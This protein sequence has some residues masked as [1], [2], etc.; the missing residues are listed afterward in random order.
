MKIF[1][2]AVAVCSLLVRVS[3]DNYGVSAK[4]IECGAFCDIEPQ[5]VYTLDKCLRQSFGDKNVTGSTEDG[6]HRK[7]A[8]MPELPLYME[9]GSEITFIDDMLFYLKAKSSHWG[10]RIPRAIVFAENS[11]DVV[12]AI[13]C[14]RKSG[15]KVT[16]RGRGHS[17]D[18]WGSADGAVVIDMQYTCDVTKMIKS[19]DRSQRGPHLIPG[20]NYIA[21]IKAQAGCSNINWLAAVYKGF[22]KEE[23]AI[24]SVRIFYYRLFLSLSNHNLT[25]FLLIYILNV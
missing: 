16:A 6:P 12:N 11:M 1:S 8:F 17:L 23:G 22:G 10:T 3:L 20:T 4:E 25:I 9:P 2:I 18:G 7:L 13:N 19:I 21:T 24:A 5:Q 15:F 14:A